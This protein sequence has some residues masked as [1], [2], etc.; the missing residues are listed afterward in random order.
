M[1]ANTWS[2]ESRLELSNVNIRWER[3]ICD[4]GGQYERGVGHS[5]IRNA[6]TCTCI[7]QLF[8]NCFLL[9]EAL[10]EE[11]RVVKWVAS[12]NKVYFYFIII[13]LKYKSSVVVPVKLVILDNRYMNMMFVGD[14]VVLIVCWCQL[15][16]GMMVFQLSKLSLCQCISVLLRWT[17]CDR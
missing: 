9:F 7:S 6:N 5:L 1:A 16:H 2:L 11:W 14:N 15:C 4:R 10:M 13:L 17:Y 12:W 8:V 3:S